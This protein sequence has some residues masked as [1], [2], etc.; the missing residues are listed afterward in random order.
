M[1]R[2]KRPWSACPNCSADLK[3]K[4]MERKPQYLLECP[5][6]GVQIVPVWWWS[7]LRSVVALVMS[8][9]IP[10]YL[11]LGKGQT[12]IF[13]WA[14]LFCVPAIFLSQILVINTILPKYVRKGQT[15]T[16][17]FQR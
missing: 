12:L 10:A 7:I 16:T 4:G 1:R 15:V 5:F 9:A 17:L 6:C 3:V 2:K 13:F 11:G 14:P 8:F